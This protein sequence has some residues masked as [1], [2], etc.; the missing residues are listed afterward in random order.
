MNV[1]THRRIKRINDRLDVWG[2]LSY[3]WHCETEWYKKAG[4]RA[5]S[6]AGFCHEEA[7]KG[8]L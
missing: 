6:V 4:C 8:C 1:A 5:Y 2:S 3:F 7:L